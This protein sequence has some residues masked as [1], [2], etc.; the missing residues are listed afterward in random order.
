MPITLD[1]YSLIFFNFPLKGYHLLWPIF[2]NMF[3]LNF[4]YLLMSLHHTRFRIRFA[5]Y[6]FQ[7]P[8]LTISLL[9]S[10]PLS[11]KMFQFLRFPFFTNENLISRFSLGNL[12]FIVF[13]QLHEAYRSLTRPSSVPRL[14]HPSDTISQSYPSHN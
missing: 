11:T 10:F 5:L 1:H 7:S 13:L 3:K 14:S 12:H 9:I 4:K 6:R 2:P 8:L